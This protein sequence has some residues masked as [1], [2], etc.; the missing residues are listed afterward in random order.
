MS[1][2]QK[3][4]TGKGQRSVAVRSIQGLKDQLRQCHLKKKKKNN[5]KIWLCLKNRYLQEMHAEVRASIKCM[6]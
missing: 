2:S 3:V 5:V 6:I 1:W 4:V